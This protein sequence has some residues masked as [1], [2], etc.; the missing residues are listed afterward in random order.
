M[1]D[2]KRCCDDGPVTVQMK[3]VGEVMPVTRP[4]HLAAKELRFVPPEST[5]KD[6]V[7]VVSSFESEPPFEQ[8]VMQINFCAMSGISPSD[9]N[10]LTTSMAKGELPSDVDVLRGGD[11]VHERVIWFA[12]DPLDKLLVVDITN[13]TALPNVR[14]GQMSVCK[15]FFTSKARA[16]SDAL[17]RLSD[18]I[19]AVTPRLSSQEA[20]D[21][22]D[23]LKEVHAL[24]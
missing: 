2:R 12:L 17:H 24:D 18:A 21:V 15:Y 9:L 13:W 14:F 16:R 6:A 20:L 3:V 22:Y 4:A 7:F 10:N 5:E 8:H 23:R 19:D 11:P 1:S